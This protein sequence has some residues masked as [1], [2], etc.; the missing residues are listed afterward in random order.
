VKDLVIFGTGGLARE[1]HQ[2]VEDINQ[3]SPEWNC[4]G[5]LD[6]NTSQHGRE[7]HGYPV[8]GGGEWLK[9]HAKTSVVIAVG[10]TAVRRRVSLELQS[11]GHQAFPTL[12]HPAARVGKWVKIGIGTIICA[13]TIVTADVEIRDFVL[14]N[15]DCTVGHDVVLEDY[16][17]VAPSV[18][19][20][21]NVVVGTGSDLGTN[22]TI[23]QGLHIGAWSII[24]AGAV[25]VKDLPRNVTAVGAPA[26]PIKERSE[27]WY[28]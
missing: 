19:I 21:G 26:K 20:S 12:I 11:A 10:N 7:V 14:V 18:N 28:V 1:V 16:V 5:F 9:D 8:L 4:I 2:L 24:G 15:L 27:G 3:V 17:T 13:D 25:V 22:S 23:I 6:G